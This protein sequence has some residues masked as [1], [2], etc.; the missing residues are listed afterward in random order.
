MIVI[1]LKKSFANQLTLGFCLVLLTT[2][3]IADDT[4]GGESIVNNFMELYE[5]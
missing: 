5:Y 4:P 1:V 3:A 2:F